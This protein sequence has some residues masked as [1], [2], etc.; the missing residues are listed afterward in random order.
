VERDVKWL[1]GY[2]VRTGVRVA[3]CCPWG[4]EGIMGAICMEWSNNREGKIRNK[5]MYKWKRE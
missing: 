2:L 3:K 1:V 4:R 5:R